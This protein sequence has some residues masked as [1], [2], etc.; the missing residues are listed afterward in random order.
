MANNLTRS[1]EISEFEKADL[2]FPGRRHILVQLHDF[3]S[4]QTRMAFTHSLQHRV[5]LYS[6]K[7]IANLK[8]QLN[9]GHIFYTLISNLLSY[10]YKSSTNVHFRIVLLQELSATL[11]P[12]L[13]ICQWSQAANATLTAPPSYASQ[14]M[15]IT[16][17][18]MNGFASDNRSP[19]ALKWLWQLLACCDL[20]DNNFV[21]ICYCFLIF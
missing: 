21:I 11:G 5:L 7:H 14:Q 6:E 10:S 1:T 3:G 18:S 12:S 9:Q 4:Y 8:T 20:N 2:D 17:Y 19:T 16:Y 15:W 13:L